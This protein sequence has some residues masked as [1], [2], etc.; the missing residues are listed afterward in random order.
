VSDVITVPKG[1]VLKNKGFGMRLHRLE[2][3]P[4]TDQLV[5][6][7]RRLTDAEGEFVYNDVWF[8]VDNAVLADLEDDPPMGLGGLEPMGDGITTKPFRTLGVIFAVTY[9]WYTEH[10]GLMVPDIK[11]ASMAMVDGNVTSYIMVVTSALNIAQGGNPERIGET[12]RRK[13]KEL[14][15]EVDKQTEVALENLGTLTPR[16]E[17]VSPSNDGLQDGQRLVGAGMS[18]GA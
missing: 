2:V 12:A 7:Y 1:L 15:D 10:N 18:S 5:K 4:G 11:R 13:L 9:G 6:P 3:L 8:R 14:Q 17:A 16:T